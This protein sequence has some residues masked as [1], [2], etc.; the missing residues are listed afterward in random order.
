[1]GVTCHQ[2]M[3]RPDSVCLLPKDDRIDGQKRDS[4]TATCPHR[5]R[6]PVSGIHGS[7]SGTVWVIRVSKPDRH[8]DLTSSVSIRFSIRSGVERRSKMSELFHQGSEEWNKPGNQSTHTEVANEPSIEHVKG[9]DNVNMFGAAATTP[10]TESRGQGQLHRPEIPT[11]NV[12]RSKSAEH[13]ETT[14]SP[15]KANPFV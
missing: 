1:M 8:R 6:A 10:T 15:K 5:G 3:S 4:V 9:V 2:Y 7:I 13:Q 11:E 14:T 12:E